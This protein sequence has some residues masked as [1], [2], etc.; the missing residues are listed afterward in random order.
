LNAEEKKLLYFKEL[1]TLDRRVYDK[2]FINDN[3]LEFQ[4]LH[5]TK[6][7]L[8]L[9]QKWRPFFIKPYYAKRTDYS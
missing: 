6:N 8:P 2:P 3:V 9:N 5:D 7:Y 4:Y 1:E